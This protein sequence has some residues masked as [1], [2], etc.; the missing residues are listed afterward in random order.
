MTKR[1][2]NFQCSPLTREQL[3]FIRAQTGHSLSTII[4]LAIA[5]MY[6]SYRSKARYESERR[7]NIMYLDEKTLKIVNAALVAAGY[8]A[9]PGDRTT[10]QPQGCG[11]GYAMNLVDSTAGADPDAR[12]EVRGIVARIVSA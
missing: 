9:Y 8:A 4:R 1:L 7:M 2:V 6:D 10:A 3:K 5:D 12:R 11:A